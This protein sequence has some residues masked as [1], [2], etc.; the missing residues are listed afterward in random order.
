MSVVGLACTHA[1]LALLELGEELKVAWD[2]GS[3]DSGL[4]EKTR[5]GARRQVLWESWQCGEGRKEVRLCRLRLQSDACCQS[6]PQLQS[7]AGGVAP[8]PCH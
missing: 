1:L 6:N 8:D 2:L 5:E 4:C 7:S 3:H